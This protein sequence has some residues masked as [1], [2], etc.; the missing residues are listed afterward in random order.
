MQKA[1]TISNTVENLIENIRKNAVKFV[2]QGVLKVFVLTIVQNKKI[3]V[4]ALQ[5]V[6]K[7]ISFKC[8]NNNFV[9]VDNS[10]ISNMHLFDDS[11]K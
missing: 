11:L 3:Q 8:K 1:R 5:K 4:S 6:N 7:K 10:S 2:S 9:F